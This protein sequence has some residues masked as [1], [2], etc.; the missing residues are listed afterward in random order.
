[1]PREELKSRLNLAPRLFN[2]ALKRLDLRDGGNWLALPGHEI[3]FTAAQQARVDGLLRQ[4][5]AAPFAPPSVK[6]SQAAGE[7][8]YLALV[9]LG[10]LK[11]VSPEVVFRQTDYE[12]MTARV[13]QFLQK[14]GQMTAAEARDLFATSRKFALALLEHLDAIGVTVRDGDVRRLKARV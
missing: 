9:E 4:F 8:V 2:A 3:R 6:E 5:A 13:R 14:N 11:Q 12:T 7:D 1:M 10:E